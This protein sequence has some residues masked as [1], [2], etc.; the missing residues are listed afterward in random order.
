M[1]NENQH[2]PNHANDAEQKR[3][4]S[5]EEKIRQADAFFG[6][7]PSQIDETP[8]VLTVKRSPLVE[9]GEPWADSGWL[10][11]GQ[12]V[13]PKSREA[14]AKLE[15]LE[16]DS[17]GNTLY[18]SD[19]EP[20]ISVKYQPLKD[21]LE[22]D[23]QQS[24]AQATEVS[25]QGEPSSEQV[26]HLD[27]TENNFDLLFAGDEYDQKVEQGV[28]SVEAAAQRGHETTE[29]QQQEMDAY[30]EVTLEAAMRND[31]QLRS[32]LENAFAGADMIVPKDKRQ[33]ITLMRT[34]EAVRRNLNDYFY[35]KTLYYRSALP[36]RVQR[37][38]NKRPNYPGEQPRPSLEV[39]ADYAVR[40]LV[41]EWN[42][43]RED[44][45]VEYNERGEVQFGQH[46]EAARTI[47][48]SPSIP[49]ERYE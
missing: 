47:L 45:E 36:E 26:A 4:H 3:V 2:T 29:E 21:V 49:N 16:H 20:V 8:H 9:G 48:T 35:N 42:Q 33:L 46:R 5:P 40:M 28:F 18:G 27:E 17:E 38:T 39:V 37:N 1:Q 25:P 31:N 15:K 32:V 11:T 12:G 43:K 24:S 10:L 44:G 30:A 23:A 7:E 19:G 13:H 41:G 6:I 22:Y 14:I 34:Q